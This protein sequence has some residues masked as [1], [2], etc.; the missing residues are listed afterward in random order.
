MRTVLPG[1]ED[2]LGPRA[3]R[4][5]GRHRARAPRG[6]RWRAARAYARG[7]FEHSPVS[8]W[9]EDFSARQAAARRGARRAASPISA[10]SPTCIRNSCSAACSEIRVI[11]VNQQTL[12]LFGA[13]DKATLLRSLREVFRDEMEPHFREQLIDLWDGKLFQQREVVNYALDGDRVD[14]LHAVLGA[15]RATSTTGRWCRSR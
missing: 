9:V 1:H 3:A 6:A 14:V 8:L 13:P 4:D 7:L 11:D 10:S 15:A 2:E 5:R 12:D